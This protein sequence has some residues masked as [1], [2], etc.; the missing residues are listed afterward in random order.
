[1]A[2]ILSENQATS[3]AKEGKVEELKNHALEEYAEVLNL[4]H[5]EIGRIQL[6]KTK[7]V[8]TSSTKGRKILFNPSPDPELGF[9]G[10]YLL[11]ESIYEEVFH[12]LTNSETLQESHGK[13]RREVG[14]GTLWDFC[15]HEI[16]GGYSRIVDDK[17]NL[18]RSFKKSRKDLVD[19]EELKPYRTIHGAIY[20]YIGYEIAAESGK[21]NT[22]ESVRDLSRKTNN[23][24]RSQFADLIEEL[25]EFLVFPGKNFGYF[26]DFDRGHFNGR[27]G[28]PVIFFKFNSELYYGKP[29]RDKSGWFE[30]EGELPEEAKPK[31]MQ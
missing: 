23:E 19:S 1:M 5:D 26:I 21:D 7:E 6:E 29:F 15:A 24:L 22:V 28:A 16:F 30:F 11:A 27:K 13:N 8:S 12:I 4:T 14:E 18:E 31:A 2:K 10:E 3:L 17:W 20:H 25:R 9:S